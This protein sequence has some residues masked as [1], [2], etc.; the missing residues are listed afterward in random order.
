[1]KQVHV[2]AG[3]IR[4]ARGRVLLARRTQGR[5]LAGL[6]DFPGGKVDKTDVPDGAAFCG[7]AALATED[8]TAR[9][10]AAREA[11]EESGIL[12]SSGPPVDAATRA[13]LRPASDRHEIGF[14]ELLGQ[15]GHSLDAG[16]LRPF[17]RW[18]PPPAPSPAKHNVPADRVPA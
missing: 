4:D 15:I 8:A 2:V 11:F 1:M 9:I 10:T 14:A 18:L 17:A 5:D 12:L 6:W 16:I 3:V 13:R 7:F